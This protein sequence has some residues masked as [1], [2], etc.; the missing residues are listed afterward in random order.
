MIVHPICDRKTWSAWRRAV[1]N[2]VIDRAV[3]DLYDRL[4]KQVA[5]R[6]PVCWVSGRC[7]QFDTFGHRLYVTGL[8]VAWVLKRVADQGST[9]ASH[10]LSVSPIHNHKVQRRKDT[11]AL[12]DSNLRLNASGA[13]PFQVNR[14]CSVHTIRPMGCRIFFC[15]HGTEQWQH[16]LYERHLGQLRA[17]HD[18]HSLPYCYMEWRTA[19]REALGAFG[20]ASPDYS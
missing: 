14:L 12:V 9:V 20:L 11:L 13:C 19:L 5:A 3:R 1:A 17:L 10:D 6:G 18:E 15:Q 16:E 2:L 7:C 4:D 8:E